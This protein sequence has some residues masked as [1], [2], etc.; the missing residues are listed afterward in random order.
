MVMDSL[1][2][3]LY[4]GWLA[5]ANGFGGGTTN[6]AWSGG[7][8]TVIAQYLMGVSVRE[9]GWK[10]F[11]VCP[12]PVRFKK[13]DISIPTIRGMVKTAFQLGETTDVYSI[14]V[15]RDT[16]A[17]YYLPCQDAAQAKGAEA[18]ICTDSKVQKEGRL[19]LLLPAGNYKFKVR[20]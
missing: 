17:Y 16:H 18:Y 6:H 9:P 7:P 10:V 3:T 8:L 11:S 2:T 15:P 5:G 14:T 12:V 1:H 4:E 20:K 13:A 19:C